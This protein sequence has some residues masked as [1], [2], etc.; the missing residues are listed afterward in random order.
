ML[1]TSGVSRSLLGD[2]R[3]SVLVLALSAALL[4]AALWA[5]L[6]PDH[7]NRLFGWLAT[8]ISLFWRGADRAAVKYR[9]EGDVNT[10]VDAFMED[11]PEGIVEAKLTVRWVNAQTASAVIA[12]GDVLVCLRRSARYDRNVANALMAYLPKAVI[13][14]ARQYL[15]SS[16]TRAID[17]VLAKSILVESGLGA[18][19]LRSFYDEH[20]QPALDADELL[21]RRV[22]RTDAIDISGWL[23]RILLQELKFYGDRLYPSTPHATYAL[24]ADRFH[25]WLYSLASRP[26][27]ALRPLAFQGDVLRVG[28]IMVAKRDK[29]EQVGLSP[30]LRWFDT[31]MNTMQ[32]DAIYLVGSDDTIEA[33]RE[34]VDLIKTDPRVQD[35]TIY[36]YDHRRQFRARTA[37]RDRAICVAIR[38]LTTAPEYVAAPESAAGAPDDIVVLRTDTLAS[39]R[40]LVTAED[41]CDIDA[42]VEDAVEQELA[43]VRALADVAAAPADGGLV[44]DE[45]DVDDSSESMPTLREVGAFILTWS[46]DRQQRGR[47][48]YVSALGWVL[49][50]RYPGSEPLHER[51]GYARISDMLRAI[52]G[53]RLSAPGPTM[54]VRIVDEDDNTDAAIQEDDV[55]RFV[56]AWVRNRERLQRPAFVSALGNALKQRFQ[57]N[58][59]VY[60][61]LGYSGLV[62]L[63]ENFDGLSVE[64]TDR[65]TVRLSESVSSRRV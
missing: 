4:L 43:E 60:E 20:L 35:Y 3:V 32:V 13:P 45:P 24:E 61:V 18:K 30:H 9:V 54:T 15:S 49:R 39:K 6:R 44:T 50:T 26:P 27:G 8:G 63:V 46:R 47:D 42:L 58:G 17:F 28:M 34:F 19:H 11:A 25:S 23:T 52:D 38:R 40:D 64:G 62:E 53:V 21:K 16:T 22:E 7:A 33:A 37:A 29:L 14:R 55:E 5:A 56:F 41:S 48:P 36:E 57:T 2:R 10:G 12:S 59:P 65:A 31:Y 1:R 51:L